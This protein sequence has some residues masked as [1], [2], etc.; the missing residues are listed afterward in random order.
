MIEVIVPEMGEA[1]MDLVF[2]RWLKH[3]GDEV[4]EGEPL[5]EVDTAK[6][7]VEVQA[8]A[9][10]ILRNLRVQEGDPIEPHQ[11]VAVLLTPEELSS[12]VA[13]TT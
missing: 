9:S 6:A 1:G 8:F 12:S 7:E 3:E 5:F 13:D 11:V 2:L 10:G 4:R